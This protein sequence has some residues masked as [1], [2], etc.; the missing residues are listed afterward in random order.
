MSTPMHDTPEHFPIPVDRDGNGP[1]S[2]D[3][4]VKVVCWCPT[5][6][7]AVGPDEWN[8]AMDAMG[9]FEIHPVSGLIKPMREGDA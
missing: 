8:K 4:T 9:P 5:P 7:C 3:D 2:L 6:G 1:A